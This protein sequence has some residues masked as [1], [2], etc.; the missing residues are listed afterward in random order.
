MKN[1][2]SK[3]AKVETT[4]IR[5]SK[6]LE[7][8]LKEMKGGNTWEEI[9]SYIADF[10]NFKASKPQGAVLAEMTLKKWFALG[11]DAKITASE[12]RK[13]TGVNL[14]ICKEVVLVYS[15]EIETFNNN[16]NSK[17]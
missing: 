13:W 10:Q 1:Q 12:I 14:N 11:F 2:D 4:T 6:D 15:A 16:L 3:K 7:T 9:I 17:K 8:K 5:I